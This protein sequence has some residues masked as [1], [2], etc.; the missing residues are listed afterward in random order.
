MT[1]D[2]LLVAR[3][4]MRALGE[5]LRAQLSDGRRG[6]VVREGVRVAILGPPNAGKSTLLNALAQH[7]AAIVSPVAGTTRDVV[8]VVLQLGGLPVEL[9]DTAGLREQT[10]DPI[11]VLGMQRA[12]EAAERAHVQLWVCDAGAA[13]QGWKALEGGAAGLGAAGGEAGE[14]G[15]TQTVQLLVHNKGDTNPNP[16]PNPSPNPDPDPNP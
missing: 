16:N 9:S 13:P 5:A 15:G 1:T 14:G 4:N 3:G 11:E 2:A 7:E 8:K 10:D 6:E 12:L